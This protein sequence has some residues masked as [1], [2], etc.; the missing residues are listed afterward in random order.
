MTG[1]APHVELLTSPWSATFFELADS[2]TN[3]LLI[4]SPFIS[5]APL[6][7]V[8]EIAKK[9]SPTDFRVE[10]IT[11]LAVDSL[12][13]GSLDIAAIL[14]LA[15]SLTNSSIT[16]LPS[17]HA[18]IYVADDKAAIVTSGNLTNNGLSVNHEYG[19]L[20]RDAALVSQ[21]RNDLLQ[22]AALGSKVSTHSLMAIN[23]AAQELKAVRQQA[24]RTVNAKLRAAF[25]RRTES[26]KFE[27]LKAR[28]QGGSTHRIFFDT[29]LYL[30]DRDGP[31]KTIELHPL[32]QKIHPD[33]CNDDIEVVIGDVHF[34]KKWKH[35]VRGAQVSLR[36]QGLIDFDGV[37]WRK[38]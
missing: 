29:I 30:L 33:L 27:L 7:R 21:V 22:Y 14:N 3:H 12:L 1:Y 18:K 31:L 35:H 11:N 20:L 24:D 16:Y 9:K 37:H 34:G 28:A 2:A 13:S 32:I 23:Q 15:Q 4:A 26:A 6:N 36:R 8:I 10:L 38:I 25:K 5:G 17:L 19:V